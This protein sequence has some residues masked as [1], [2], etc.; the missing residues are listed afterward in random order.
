M[1]P[2]PVNQGTRP[3][4]NYIVTSYG[5]NTFWKNV[6]LNN[7]VPLTINPIVSV[8]STSSLM[9]G[10]SALFTMSCPFLLVSESPSP[11]GLFSHR[12]G[13]ALCLLEFSINWKEADFQK[14]PDELPHESIVKTS[15]AQ[16]LLHLFGLPITLLF[17]FQNSLLCF[18]LSGV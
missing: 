14:E 10:L 2:I 11:E 17:F 9:I 13:E 7:C 12:D 8:S 18:P 1:F 3:L 4:P 16:T 6:A 5:Q 15:N